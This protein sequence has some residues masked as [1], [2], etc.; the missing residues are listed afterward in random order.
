MPDLNVLLSFAAAALVLL[1][2]PG[3]G[4]VYVI[5]R[6]ASQGRGAGLMSVLGLSAGALVHVI[7]ATVGLSA[8]LYASANAFA[9]VKA[10]GAAYLIYLGL[11]TLLVREPPPSTNARSAPRTLRR[12]FVDGVIVSVLNPKLAVFFLAFLPQ[13]VAPVG[14]PATL[15]VFAL[16]LLYVGLAL[17]T[18]GAYVLLTSR[19]SRWLQRPAMSGAAPRYASGAIYIGMGVSTALI[20]RSPVEPAR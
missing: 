17:L 1:I 13:F 12:L 7:A 6:T 8:V 9:V 5:A 20:D 3:P 14:L 18:D 16:G 11:R 10:L 15:Q 19:I 2:I 4:V